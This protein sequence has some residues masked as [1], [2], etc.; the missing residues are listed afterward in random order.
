M[1]TPEESRAW[2]SRLFGIL[3]LALGIL[4]LA[5]RLGY[6][7]ACADLGSD[8]GIDAPWARA[9]FRLGALLAALAG[10]ASA[11]AA[12]LAASSWKK[13]LGLPLPGFLVNGMALLWLF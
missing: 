11:L 8:L 2:T 5:A 7:V 10:L 1:P 9:L 13:R 6:E 3:S 12:F 4:A